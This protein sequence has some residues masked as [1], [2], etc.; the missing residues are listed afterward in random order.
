MFDALPATSRIIGTQLQRRRCIGAQVYVS[1]GDEVVVDEGIGEAAAGTPMRRDTIVNWFCATK[2]VIA[3][4]MAQLCERGDLQPTTHIADIIPE[5]TPPGSDGAKVVHLLTHTMPFENDTAAGM[6]LAPWDEVIAAICSSRLQE[7]VAPGDAVVYTDHTAFFLLAEIIRRVTGE[8]A[9]D[10]VRRHIF[11][12][13]GML[14]SWLGMPPERFA[15]YGDRIAVHH[16]THFGDP[17][18]IPFFDTPEVCSRA[19]PGW[20]AR[21]PISELALLIGALRDGARGRSGPTAVLGDDGIATLMAIWRRNLP[22]VRYG[23]A[24]DWGFGVV[25]DP[26]FLGG[27]RASSAVFGHDGEAVVAFADPPR[28][29]AATVMFNGLGSS[30]RAMVRNRS[31]MS[32]ILRDV[33]SVPARSTLPRHPTRQGVPS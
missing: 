26:Q 17:V 7:G 13:L 31:L 25:R 19:L 29:L 32:A 20:G 1:V 15:A 14:D 28:D 33:D 11:E 9:G 24:I 12:P 3:V 8:T 2:I 5:F 21:G 30:F 23:G 10:Y 27:A 16:S 22:C 6:A 18:P 4:A